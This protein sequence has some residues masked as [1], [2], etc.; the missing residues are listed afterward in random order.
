MPLEFV[1]SK[2]FSH[3]LKVAKCRDVQ[4]ASNTFLTYIRYMQN[5]DL[6]GFVL[7]NDE[8]VSSGCSLPTSC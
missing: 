5:V 6:D 3:A 2:T 4:L 8:S 7:L 1:E